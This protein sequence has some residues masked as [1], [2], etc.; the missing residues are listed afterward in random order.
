MFSNL[1]QRVVLMLLVGAA[2]HV[3]AAPAPVSDLGGSDSSTATATVNNTVTQETEVQRLERL[4]KSR[5]QLQ[6]QMQQ[7]LD[8]MTADIQQLRGQLEKNTHEMKQMLTRQRELFVELDRLRSEIKT[9]EFKDTQADTKKSGGTFSENVDEQQAYQNAV[10]LILK[11]RDYAG[12]IQAFN[13]FQKDY[14]KSNFSPNAYYWL[15]QLYYAKQQDD[16]AIESFKAVLKFSKSNKRAD[17][18]VKLGDIEKR[19]HHKE[20]ANQY[21]QQVIREYPDSASADVAKKSIMP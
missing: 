18:L 21:Y 2:S 4:L 15:G 17:A 5:N 6:I 10:D 20:Q 1:Q 8:D 7:Q 11:K 14:P 13:Q 19:N 9:D 3:L 12:A 16:K